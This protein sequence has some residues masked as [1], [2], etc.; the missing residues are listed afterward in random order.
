MSSD[1]EKLE[2]LSKRIRQAKAEKEQKPKEE[3]SPWRNAG[4]DLGGTL[5]G[6]IIFGVL[7]DRLFGTAPWILVGMVVMGFITG[8]MGIWK[9]MQRPDNSDKDDDRSIKG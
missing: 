6:S 5:I 1:K 4:Y 9:M 3:E 8:L 7:L 2:N